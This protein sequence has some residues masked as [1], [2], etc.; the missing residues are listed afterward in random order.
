MYSSCEFYAIVVLETLTDYTL[1][2]QYQNYL[3]NFLTKL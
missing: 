3:I 2:D 1:F